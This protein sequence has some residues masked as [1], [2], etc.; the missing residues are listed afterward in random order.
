[1]AYRGPKTAE[2]DDLLRL[3]ISSRGHDDRPQAVVS[4]HE[5]TPHAGGSFHRRNRSYRAV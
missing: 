2:H 5:A 4:C 3:W 1:M